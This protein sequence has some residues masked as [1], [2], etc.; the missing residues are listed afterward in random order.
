MDLDKANI[1]IADDEPNTLKV[2]SAIFCGEG[3]NVYSSADGKK[4]MDIMDNQNIDAVITDLKMPGRDGMELFDFIMEKHPDTPVI[5]LTAYGTVESAARALANGAF[6]YF[7]KPPDFLKLRKILERAVEHRRLKTELEYLR[8]RLGCRRRSSLTGRTEGMLKIAEI[9]GSVKDSASSVLISGETGTGKELMAKALHYGGI[10]KLKP[11]VAVNC[12]A[13]PGDLIEP[14]LFGYERGVFAGACA[15]RAGKLEEAGAGTLFL[16]EIG[17]LELPLQAKLLRV[18]QEREMQ[19]TGGA[20]KIKMNF[21]LVCSTKRDLRAEVRKGNFREDLF[22]RI[23]VVHIAIPPLR[24]RAEDVP[25]LAAE[26]L[27]EYCL[28]EGKKVVI[29]TDIMEML[30]RYPWPG[31]VRQLRNVIERAVVLAPEGAITPRELPPEMLQ[32]KK[33]QALGV[34]LK[35]LKELEIQA[36]RKALSHCGGNKSKAAKVL[37]I[38]RKSFYK[39]LSGAI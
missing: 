11:F 1:L 29:P 37:G 34:S 23:N 15:R 33:H 13:I 39:K 18:L 3:Y 38:S 28:R 5:F 7:V 9:I 10:R 16:D 31:N 20:R 27:N 19:R 6:Y 4:A 22:Y 36:I 35:T 24:E 32:F 25:L 17:E 12:A 8:V 21:R 2:L 26:F 30:Q 14:E